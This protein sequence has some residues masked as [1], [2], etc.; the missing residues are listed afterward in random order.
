MQVI[1]CGITAPSA[2]GFINALQYELIDVSALLLDW[3][4]HTRI[5]IQHIQKETTVCQ[6]SCR[7]FALNDTE[8][9]DIQQIW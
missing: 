5:D 2:G 3:A 8:R 6:L 7:E 4:A 9:Q 1:I